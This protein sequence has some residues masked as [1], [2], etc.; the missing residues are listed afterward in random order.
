MF[1]AIHGVGFP[2]FKSVSTVTGPSNLAETNAC[3]G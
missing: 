3:N 1:F 2:R